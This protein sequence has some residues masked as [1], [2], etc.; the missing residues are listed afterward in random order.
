M[1]KLEINKYLYKLEINCVYLFGF[2]LDTAYNDFLA[3]TEKIREDEE[4]QQQQEE[5]RKAKVLKNQD[6]YEKVCAKFFLFL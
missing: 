4:Q 1:Y 6:S 3:L 2:F 5:Q